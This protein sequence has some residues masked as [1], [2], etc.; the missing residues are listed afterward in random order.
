M[1]KTKLAGAL[2]LCGAL[3]LAGCSSPAAR[4][5]ARYKSGLKGLN[6]LFFALAKIKQKD[7]FKTA[8]PEIRDIIAQVNDLK[9]LIDDAEPKEEKIRDQ[10]RQSMAPMLGAVLFNITLERLRHSTIEGASLSPEVNK[11]ITEA[12]Q[13]YM[14][15]IPPPKNANPPPAVVP[16]R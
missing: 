12:C 4:Y 8:N 13:S 11:S 6:E 14:K 5:K 15:L 9:S 2:F 1:S 7:E 3:F 10:V 16:G